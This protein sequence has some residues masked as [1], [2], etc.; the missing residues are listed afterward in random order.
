VFLTNWG[1]G[2]VKSGMWPGL[3]VGSGVAALSV[4]VVVAMFLTL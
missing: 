4:V 2:G 1:S 3:L